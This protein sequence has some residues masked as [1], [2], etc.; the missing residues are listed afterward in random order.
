MAIEEL[1]N[2]KEALEAERDEVGEAYD[3]RIEA[4]EDYSAQWEEITDSFE[5]QQNRLAAA[6]LLGAEW[7]A[8]ILS[9][10][11]DSLKQFASD[12]HIPE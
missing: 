11:T 10:R 1:E 5:T 7:E 9:M 4:L 2:Q 12:Y 6:E 8:D 3:A